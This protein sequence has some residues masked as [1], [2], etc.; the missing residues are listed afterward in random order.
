MDQIKQLQTEL[1][2]D[3]VVFE[4]SNLSEKQIEEIEKTYNDI[5]L[6]LHTIDRSK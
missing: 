3:L 1:A 4:D 5:Y 6:K 2:R